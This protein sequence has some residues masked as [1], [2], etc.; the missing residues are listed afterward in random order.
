MKRLQKIIIPFLYVAALPLLSA[1]GCAPRTLTLPITDNF[2]ADC[3]WP[4]GEDHIYSYGC[5]Q[6]A[7]RVRL[8]KPGPVNIKM[9][10]IPR[11]SAVSAEADATVV[12]GKGTE[13]GKKNADLGIGCLY[14]SNQGYV[15]IMGTDG[16]WAIMRLDGNQFIQLAGTNEPGQIP[17]L[18]R[19]NR[20]RIVCDDKGMFVAAN[21]VI[22]FF[23]NGNKV[24]SAEST[25][26]PYGQQ[27][28]GFMLYTD[29]WP[30][31]VAFE[32]FAA[33]GRAE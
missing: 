13:P 17:G 23:V 7:Y 18:G 15:V 6:G 14:D 9:G 16:S 22:S 30:G 31:E 8:K 10:F 28:R 26:P 24:G 21:S 19:T 2:P 27:Y 20:L 11:S 12:S 33:D 32:R 25:K 29:T 4:R 3:A 1:M 5:D